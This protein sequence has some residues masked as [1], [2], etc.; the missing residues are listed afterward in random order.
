MSTIAGTGKKGL[1]GIS[2]TDPLAMDLRSP[3]DLALDGDSLY[4]AMAGDHQ[5]WRMDLR[6][7]R[8]GPFAGSGREGIRDG[9]LSRATFSQPSGLALQGHRLYVADPEASAIREID[10]SEGRVRTLVGTG[11]FDFGDR[12]GELSKAQ[13]QHAL[14]I[15]FWKD[16]KLLIADT[17]NH[18]LKLLD[19]EAGQVST[20]LGT[21]E[22]GDLIAD[23]GAML[24][25]PAGLALL[26]D[27][28][29]IADTNNSRILIFDPDKHS[30]EVLEPA[31]R[32]KKSA[33]GTP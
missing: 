11:L 23:S 13:L 9:R 28:V 18:K 3:W 31:I 16:G 24:N 10:L 14:A 8:I 25:E 15:T 19:L 22:P 2:E 33:E 20:L 5:I 1:R 30:L 12:D 26:G 21:G 7:N 6:R 17:Y 27:K 32:K 29:L 4:I